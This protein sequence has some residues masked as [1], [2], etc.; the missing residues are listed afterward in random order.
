[1]SAN[2]L[3]DELVRLGLERDAIQKAVWENLAKI[4]AAAL[5][6]LAQGSTPAQVAH[7]AGVNVATVKGWRAAERAT[8][9]SQ[10]AGTSGAPSRA[11]A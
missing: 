4:R 5:R 8:K 7:L 3:A 1:M 6:L 2:G 9:S 10:S 11:H